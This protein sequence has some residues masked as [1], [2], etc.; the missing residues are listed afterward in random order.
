M[1]IRLEVYVTN[2]HDLY[3]PKI[4]FYTVKV[5]FCLGKF[6]DNDSANCLCICLYINLIA[7]TIHVF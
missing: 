5:Y 6:D 4:D 1:K 2:N 3:V 7:S